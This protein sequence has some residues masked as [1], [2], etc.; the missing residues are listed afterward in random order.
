MK[1]QETNHHNKL[2]IADQWI[3]KEKEENRGKS[4]VSWPIHL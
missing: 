2:S 3:E 4:I 1:N